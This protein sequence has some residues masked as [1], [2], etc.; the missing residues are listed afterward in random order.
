MRVAELTPN[1][2]VNRLLDLSGARMADTSKPFGFCSLSE[3]GCL[4]CRGDYNHLLQL[5]GHGALGNATQTRRT[6]R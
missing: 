2:C 1:F 3:A 4:C 5:V 6:V